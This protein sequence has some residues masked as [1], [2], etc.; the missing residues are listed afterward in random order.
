MRNRTSL[1]IFVALSLAWVSG[2][3]R[4]EGAEVTGA[5]VLAGT[6]LD[7]AQESPRIVDG[8]D[9]L[10]VS[11]EM[12]DFVKANVHRRNTDQVRLQELIDAIINQR[13][14]GLTFDGTTRT[15]SETFTLRKG[16]CLSFSNLF[17]AMARS[18]GLD[19][20]YQEV[21]IPPDWT[22]DNDVFVLNK[23]VN[24]RIGLGSVDDRVVD[25]NIDDFRTSY[26]TRTISDAR[27]RAHYYNNIGVER[28]QAGDTA[29]AFACFRR[30]IAGNDRRFSPAWT[31]LG[32]LY[33]RNGLPTY[34]ETAYL[35][36]LRIDREDAVAMSNLVR[37]YERQGDTERAEAYRKKVARH[38]N[39]NPY[40]RF[41]RAREAFLAHDYN[42]AI[43]N[44]KYAIRKRGQEDQFLFL[45]GAI[46]LQKGNEAAAR[47]WLARAQEAAATPVLKR[48]YSGKIDLLLRMTR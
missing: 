5:D 22:L 38:R 1:V 39:Q 14:F 11:D 44:V 25:F 48:R 37:L 35:Q 43:S 7:V 45:L 30:A 42:A 3:A 31:N 41:H 9:V 46:Y 6:A 4:C 27:A 29:A 10:A 16:N 12:R 23:H 26:D 32:T 8:V 2:S 13:T 18:V 17:I 19:A 34:A 20:R 15:A 21:D 47:R 40:Y 33:L 28:M 24:V 36:A